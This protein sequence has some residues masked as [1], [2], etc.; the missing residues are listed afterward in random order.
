VRT[1]RWNG[2]TGL[3]DTTPDLILNSIDELPAHLT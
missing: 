1:G 3:L 2:D